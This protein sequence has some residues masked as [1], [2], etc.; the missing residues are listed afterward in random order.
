M[1]KRIK[2]ILSD[3]DLNDLSVLAGAGVFIWGVWQ[4]YPPAAM[5]LAGAGMVWWGLAGSRKARSK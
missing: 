3:F 2:T 5:I 4:I 1:K